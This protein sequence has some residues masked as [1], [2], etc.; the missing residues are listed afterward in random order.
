M[1]DKTVPMHKLVEETRRRHERIDEDRRLGEG[2]LGDDELLSLLVVP[3]P[4]PLGQ[5]N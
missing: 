4:T 1:R 2:R 5:R 3:Y